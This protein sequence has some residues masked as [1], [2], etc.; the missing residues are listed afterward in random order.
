MGRRGVLS[1]Y[2]S[3]IAVMSVLVCGCATE[4]GL[5]P[6]V[7]RPPGESLQPP[8]VNALF[9]GTG[10]PVPRPDTALVEVY[11]RTSPPSREVIVIGTVE[12]FTENDTRTNE[13]MLWYARREA[14]RLGGDA[15]VNLETS[16]LVTDPGGVSG[17]TTTL[18][19]FKDFSGNPV[20][21]TDV[22]TYGATVRRIMKADIAVWRTTK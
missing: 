3:L 19:P 22:T 8:H 9:L 2:A 14:R 12:V 16:Q 17:S 20:V 6:E 7:P 18:S 11:T 21:K 1:G 10:V 5:T 4:H 15:L 13:N